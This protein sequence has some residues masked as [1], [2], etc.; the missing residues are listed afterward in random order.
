MGYVQSNGKCIPRARRQLPL[1]PFHNVF[2]YPVRRLS[3]SEES[4]LM[5]V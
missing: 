3:F 1:K 5:A 2:D 4:F